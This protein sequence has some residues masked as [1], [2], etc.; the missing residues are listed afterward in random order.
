MTRARARGFGR[1]MMIRGDD[2]SAEDVWRDQTELAPRAVVAVVRDCRD[3][4]NLCYVKLPPSPLIPPYDSP[5]RPPATR[6]IPF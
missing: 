6:A 2:R 3:L 4:R 5:S 1:E